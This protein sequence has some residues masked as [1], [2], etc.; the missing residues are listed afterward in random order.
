MTRFMKFGVLALLLTGG[1]EDTGTGK[2]E[3]NPEAAPAVG[4]QAQ[5]IGTVSNAA[6][7]GWTRTP[8]LAAARLLHSAIKLQ[9]GRV[10]VVGG[11]NPSVEVYDP[12]TGTWSQTGAA[13]ASFHRPTATLLSNGKVLVV[14]GT[15][16]GV[17]TALFDPA[18][19]TWTTPAPLS[20]ARYH[21]TATLL[22]NGKVLVTGGASGEYGGAALGSAELYDPATGAWTAAGSLGTARAHHTATLLSNGKVLVSGGEGASGRLTSAELYDPATGTWTAAGALGTARADHSA[23]VLANG[24]VL[25]SGGA[26]DGEPSTRAELYDPATGTWSATGA[27]SQP[28]HL[29]TATVLANGKVLVTGGYDTSTGIQTASELY[30]PA[31]GVWDTVPAMGVS[32]YQHTATLLNNGRVLVVGGISTGDQASAEVFSALYVQVVLDTG[33]GWELINASGGN[34]DSATGPF[35]SDLYVVS[36]DLGIANAPMPEGLRTQLADRSVGKTTMFFLDK[37]I[38]EE[39]RASE[40]QGSL[41]P[42]LQSIASPPASGFNALSFG[43][44]DEHASWGHTFDFTSNLNYQKDLGSGF[45]GSIT[46]SGNLTAQASG[47]LNM[48]VPRY[49]L[50][51]LCIPVGASFESFKV[52]GDGALNYGATVNGTIAYANTWAFPIAKPNLVTMPFMAGPVPVV[53]GLNLPIT[54]GIDVAANATTS[55][56]YAATQSTSVHFGVDC[57]PDGCTSV[58]TASM[59]PPSGLNATGSISG[60]VQPSVWAQAAVRLFLYTDELAYG[61]AGVRPYIDGDL[62]GYSGNNCGDGDGDGTEEFVQGGYFDLN[63]RLNVT[64]EVGLIFLGA[65]QWNDI[66]STGKR[67]LYFQNLVS[68]VP[69]GANALAPMLVGT[70]NPGQ[71][72]STGYTIRMRPCF[73]FEKDNALASPASLQQDNAIT[74]RVDWG[75]GTAPTEFTGARF[76]ETFLK[77][78]RWTTFGDKTVQVTALH[79]SHGRTLNTP[80]TRTIQV[81]HQNDPAHPPEYYRAVHVTG[82]LEAMEEDLLGNKYATIPI[83][84][85]AYLEDGHESETWSYSKCVDDE[86]RM[87]VTLTLTRASNKTDVSVSA[88]GK[89]YEGWSC[90]NTDLDAETT[91]VVDVV[92]D[93]A[94]PLYFKIKNGESG[95]NDYLKVDLTVS[96]DEEEM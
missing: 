71:Y 5:A 94:A 65:K 10:L 22:G 36:D 93:S 64:G 45:T 18:S 83:D 88:H 37:R 85:T 89:L 24:Q 47:E 84:Q 75:D 73:P 62:W 23:T 60:R 79:D 38:L 13:P 20:T 76:D 72:D 17:T 44:P 34:T 42:Y 50:F 53:V 95:S 8:N 31:R 27:M 2:P 12:A 49:G 80:F 29:H 32:R 25:V 43:C 48:N 91:N 74:Y 90:S 33:T 86:V 26:A 61:Q 21:H 96:N 77:R 11:Y 82:V 92:R 28:R 54:V 66:F 19:G 35:N 30:D 39:I 9:D 59:P 56:T 41:T 46:T 14:G 78:H 51:G 40:L 69:G 70:G 58:T 7:T 16:V 57:T 3:G 4:M 67:H 1:C 52:S 6:E 68:S 81:F 87:E 55:L 63:W 15:D